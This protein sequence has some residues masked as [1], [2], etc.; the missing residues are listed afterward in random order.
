MSVSYTH[1]DVYKRQVCVCVCVCV[2]EHARACVRATHGMYTYFVW[3]KVNQFLY[4]YYFVVFL[5]NKT[6]C[7]C[8][9][10]KSF[11]YFSKYTIIIV[12]LKIIIN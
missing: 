9:T 6:V 1:L 7:V 3:W 12:A 4:P 11:S 8:V 5:S 10:F 2:C